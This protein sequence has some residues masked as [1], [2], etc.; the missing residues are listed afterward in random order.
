LYVKLCFVASK[1]VFVE[2]SVENDHGQCW[3]FGFGAV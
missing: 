3:K 2:Q 1:F